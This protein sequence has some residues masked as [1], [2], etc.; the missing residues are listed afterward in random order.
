MSPNQPPQQGQPDPKPLWVHSP[1]GVF[2]WR[3]EYA[4]YWKGPAKDRVWVPSM[5]TPLHLPP[6][7]DIGA[8]QGDAAGGPPAIQFGSNAPIQPHTPA[9]AGYHN[10][11]HQNQ[12]ATPAVASVSAPP[13]P[14]PPLNAPLPYLN[15]G[16][17]S[18]GPSHQ[19]QPN[20]NGTGFMSMQHW[21]TALSHDRRD[22]VPRTLVCDWVQP[23]RE[24]PRREAPAP[25]YN[26]FGDDRRESGFDRAEITARARIIDPGS[27]LGGN[28]PATSTPKHDASPIAP[29]PMSYRKGRATSNS[30][31]QPVPPNC[32]TAD[33]GANGHPRLPARRGV[34]TDDES[35]YGG[36]GSDDDDPSKIKNYNVKEST[37]QAQAVQR[38][39]NGSL[40]K[41][42]RPIKRP[43]AATLGIWSDLRYDTVPEARNLI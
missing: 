43:P 6:P 3:H 8:E 13:P 9:Q 38:R 15:L 37:C 10:P 21:L 30:S 2:Y 22:N 39:N 36:S 27:T 17:Q 4:S 35:D 42:G 7:P 16:P 33:R 24:P 18:S 1:K 12:P 31:E 14:P 19:P 20:S 5:D 26:Y 29:R 25:N 28:L 34:D 23:R 41:P 32:N 40:G 11:L